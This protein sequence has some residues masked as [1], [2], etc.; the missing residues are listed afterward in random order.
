MRRIW[1]Y[2]QRKK[3]FTIARQ[4]SLRNHRKCSGANPGETVTEHHC[5]NVV[6]RELPRESKDGRLH[7]G[8]DAAEE[9]CEAKNNDEPNK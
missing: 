1:L 3:K 6:L 9:R 7:D 2:K 4:S 8:G 5:A